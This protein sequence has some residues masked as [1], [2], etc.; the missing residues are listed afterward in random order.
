MKYKD[1]SFL[2]LSAEELNSLL[3]SYNKHIL[4]QSKYLFHFKALY[5]T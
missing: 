5:G 2:A 3:N 1:V 4:R